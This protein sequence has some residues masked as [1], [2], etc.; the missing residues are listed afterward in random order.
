[1]RRFT[2]TLLLLLPILAFASSQQDFFNRLKSLVTNEIK[3]IKQQRSEISDWQK[4]LKQGQQLSLAKQTKARLLASNYG[5]KGFHA[6]ETKSYDALL[7]RVDIVPVSMV[8]AQAAD[9]SAWGRSRFAVQ[10]HNLFGQ[11][12]FLPGCGIVPKRR[13][14]GATYE[15]QRFKNEQQAINRYFHN[16][17]TGASYAKFRQLRALQRNKGTH[18]SGLVLAEGLQH[19]SSRGLTYVREIQT[20]IRRYRLNQYDTN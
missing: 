12:C 11:W 16:L 5:L 8:L 4:T 15:V 6:T 20:I 3:A 10:G 1:M 2:L 18:L 7:A 19:Y 13:P 14:K 9:E 17:N